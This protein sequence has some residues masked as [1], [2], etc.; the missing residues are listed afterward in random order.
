MLIKSN[1]MTERGNINTNN[2]NNTEANAD[3]I[4][5]VKLMIS[6]L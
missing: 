2:E 5:K 4:M 6:I 1:W 3:K